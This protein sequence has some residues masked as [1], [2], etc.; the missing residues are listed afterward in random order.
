MNKAELEYG[1]KI[2]LPQSAFKQVNRLRL[3]FPLYFW[4][5]SEA[6]AKAG[7]LHCSSFSRSHEHAFLF[8]ADNAMMDSVMN[9]AKKGA[10]VA[11]KAKEV[12][13]YCGVLEF[14]APENSMYAPA[15]L[16]KNIQVKEGGKVTLK[17]ETPVAKG[18]YCK[19]QPH[20]GEF[21]NILSEYG[22]RFMLESAFRGYAVLSEGERLCV[23][24]GG[25]KFGLTVLETKPRPIISILENTDLEVDFA[26]PLTPVPAS[27]AA[28]SSA[29]PC[30]LLVRFVC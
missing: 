14:S 21:V 25:Q 16:M 10:K 12:Q 23:K 26:P 22:A 17:S 9:P 13:Q 27:S 4:V 5:R 18:Q 1:D 24:F 7:L 2:I 19:L 30:T 3:P 11:V 20:E 15:W 8:A 6:K 29:L 28:A